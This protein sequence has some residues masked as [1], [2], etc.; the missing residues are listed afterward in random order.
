MV[1]ELYNPDTD[2]EDYELDETGLRK[3][4]KPLSKNLTFSD[5]SATDLSRSP[6][7]SSLTITSF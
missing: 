1:A 6:C 5:S 4:V 3:E 7:G 2:R